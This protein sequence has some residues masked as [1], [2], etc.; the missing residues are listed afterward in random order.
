MRLTLLAG[1]A[2]GLLAGAAV[3]ASAVTPPVKHVWVLVLEN[4]NAD[5][6]F[7]ADSKAPYLAKTLTSQG[8]F[9][10]NYYATGHESLDN[11]ISMISGQ[12][13]NPQ[14]QSDCQF[15]TEF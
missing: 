2:L 13:P 8:E 12:A 11:Y 7:G 14:T 9:L 3:P 4:E 6:T 1:L 10:P 15:F 5:S